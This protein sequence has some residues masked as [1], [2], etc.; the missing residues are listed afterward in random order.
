MHH[1]RKLMMSN[2]HSQI[3]EDIPEEADEGPDEQVEFLRLEVDIVGTE[4]QGPGMPSSEFDFSRP[5]DPTKPIELTQ[6]N[7]I[8]R[9][10]TALK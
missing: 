9:T 3:E 2:A 6:S 7:N 1:Q 5:T 4:S 8:S 10:P